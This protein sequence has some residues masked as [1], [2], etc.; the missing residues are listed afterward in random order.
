MFP[1]LEIRPKSPTASFSHSVRKWH[2]TDEG[3][4]EQRSDFSSLEPTE[5]SDIDLIPERQI[6]FAKAETDKVR[7]Q[8]EQIAGCQKLEE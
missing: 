7:T 5:P 2:K 1:G 8:R 4:E 3:R 6:E